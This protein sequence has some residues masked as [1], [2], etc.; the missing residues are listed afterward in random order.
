M[1]DRTLIINRTNE[2]AENA[3]DGQKKEQTK[4]E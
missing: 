2:T 1:V 4:E 3:I